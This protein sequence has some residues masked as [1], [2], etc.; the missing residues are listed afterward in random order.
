MK[1]L[2][3]DDETFA[4]RLLTH[5]LKKLGF[6]DVTSFDDPTAA[7]ALLEQDV[8]VADLILLDLQMPG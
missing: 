3:V 1:L 6:E 5:Q 4:L 2:L 8:H 7:L